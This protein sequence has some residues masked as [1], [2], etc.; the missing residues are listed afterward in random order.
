MYFRGTAGAPVIVSMSATAAAGPAM[1]ASA[2]STSTVPRPPAGSK[3]SGPAILHVS[4]PGSEGVGNYVARMAE[5]QTGLGYR[6]ELAC[7]VDTP[8]ARAGER[9]G[10]RVH[11]WSARRHPDHDLSG[12]LAQLRAI[13]G[14]ADPDV[15]HLH[16]S[17]AGLVGRLVLRRRRPTV[18]QPHAWSFDAVAPG[19]SLAAI[20]WERFAGRWT[21]VLVAVSDDEMATA[22]RHGIVAAGTMMTVPNPVDTDRFHPRVPDPSET[23]YVRRSLGLGDEPLVVCVGR[24]CHQKGQDRLLQLWPRVLERVP[25]AQLL[26]VGDGPDR[27][28][29]EARAGPHVHF[30]GNRS[31]VAAILRASQVVVMPSR[32]EGMSMAVLEALASSRPVVASEVAGAGETVGQ[33]AGAVVGQGDVAA[34]AV[35]IVARLVD[36][37]RARREGAAGRR[38]VAERHRFTAAT[39]ALDVAYRYSVDLHRCG[40]NGAGARARG[41]RVDG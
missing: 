21:D 18:F 26:L 9:S 8:L 13:V 31:D 33:G 34:M 6:V 35:E 32:W 36:P 7:P 22:T 10:I 17:K 41:A 5:I 14:R 23:R 39:E 28:A 20:G 15:V 27:A 30:L 24:L 4:Q 16:S 25:A 29:L 38:I 3:P 37:A 2:P 12:E 1:P 19:L 11:R 40:P